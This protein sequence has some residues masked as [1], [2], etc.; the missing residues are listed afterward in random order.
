VHTSARV[1]E[2]E[3]RD[4]VTMIRPR[5][6]Q[7]SQWVT[8]DLPGLVQSGREAAIKALEDYPELGL[9]TAVAEIPRRLAAFFRPPTPPQ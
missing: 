9:K 8:T 7:R 3:I 6:G 1:H 5:I 2:F 4:D